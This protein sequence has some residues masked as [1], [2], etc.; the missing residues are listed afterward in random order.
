[1]NTKKIIDQRKKLNLTQEQVANIV[2]ITL[3]YYYKI[4]KGISVPNV[5]IGLKIAKVLKADPF[6]LFDVNK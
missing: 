5:I 1:M 3:S 2:G 4:E 6:A